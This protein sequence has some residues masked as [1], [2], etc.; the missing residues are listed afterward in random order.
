MQH[1]RISLQRKYSLWN[2]TLRRK[3]ATSLTKMFFLAAEQNCVRK[4]SLAA[5]LTF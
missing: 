4:H 2:L 1:A 5:G 3:F